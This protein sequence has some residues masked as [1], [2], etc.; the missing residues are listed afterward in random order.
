MLL[1]AKAKSTENLGAPFSVCALV[2]E[3]DAIQLP[4]QVCVPDP[5]EILLK[6]CVTW[7]IMSANGFKTSGTVIIVM[8]PLMVVVT[9]Q[10]SVQ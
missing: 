7:L 3:L 5:A 2:G 9:A 6:T 8:V 4:S 1:A 10:E